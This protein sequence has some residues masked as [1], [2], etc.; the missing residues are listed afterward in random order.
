MN[1]IIK[2]FKKSSVYALIILLAVLMIYYLFETKPFQIKN[3]NIKGNSFLTKSSIKD[4]IKINNKTILN[5]DF[6]SLKKLLLKNN[7]IQDVKIYIEFPNSL[8]INIIEINPIAVI[9]EKEKIFF[10]DE[11]LNL[12]P[13]DI[14][15][16]NHF[17]NI[18]IITNL[19][20]NN[21]NLNLSGEIVSKILNNAKNIYDNLNELRYYNNKTKLYIGENT[22]I[23]I[24]NQNLKND[25][26]KLFSF[27][28]QF[29]K[30]NN[31]SI[32]KKYKQINLTV[33]NQIITLEKNETI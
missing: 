1:K 17:T 18:P 10:I 31:I 16:L 28:N 7:Y 22:E 21:I 2:Y 6:K 5:I 3:I 20:G 14:E 24:N 32:D 9:E 12:I 29:I 13:I 23:I 8:N 4:Q 26:N 27:N 25:L 11:K 15:A 33:K 19:S 30:K